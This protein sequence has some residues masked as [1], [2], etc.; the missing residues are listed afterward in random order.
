MA[1]GWD[2]VFID[3]SCEKLQQLTDRICQCLDRLDGD[4][5]WFRGSE[6]EN[7]VGN[8]VLHL[9]GNVRQWIGFG[10]DAR[11]DI[12][13][14]DIEFTTRG[15]VGPDELKERLRAAVSEATEILRRLTAD[16]L[17]EIIKVQGYEMPVLA[18][19]YHVVEHFSGHAGQIIFCTKQFTGW[20]PGFYSHL[21]STRPDREQAPQMPNSPRPSALP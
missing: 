1:I 11:P 15:G 2:R 4:K 19:V 13:K 6:N 7:A 14:R 9:C 16:R 10:V 5:I 12:R 3:F 17:E 18:A 20:N 8:L 21:G